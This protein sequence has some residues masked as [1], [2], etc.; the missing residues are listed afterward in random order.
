MPLLSQEERVLQSEG[1]INPPD[2]D[3]AQVFVEDTGVETGAEKTP[4]LGPTIRRPRPGE[5]FIPPMGTQSVPTRSTDAPS[6]VVRRAKKSDKIIYKNPEQQAKQEVGVTTRELMNMP[7]EEKA[8]MNAIRRLEREAQEEEKAERIRNQISTSLP[9]GTQYDDQERFASWN[10]LAML[11]EMDIA[12]SGDL[13][14]KQLKFRESFPEGSLIK[15]ETTDGGVYLARP[16]KNT[17]YRKLGLAPEIAGAIFSEPSVLAGLG[18]VVG[19]V[20]SLGIAPGITTPVLAGAGAAAGSFLQG[21]IE[22]AR[23]YEDSTH[24]TQQA[25]TEGGVA[26]VSEVAFRGMGRILGGRMRTTSEAKALRRAMQTVEELGLEPLVFGQT[27]GPMARGTFRQMGTISPKIERKLTEQQEGLLNYFRARGNDVPAGTSDEVLQEVINAKT[28][29]FSKLIEPGSLT[30]AGAGNTLQAGIEEY[31]KFSRV[32]RDRLYDAA[33]ETT[34]DITFNLHPAQIV[35]AD[36]KVGVL[37]KGKDKIETVTS[38]ILGPDGLPVTR[39]ITTPS[40]PVNVAGNPTGVL[41]SVIND[42]LALDP[43]MSKFGLE[44]RTWTA[45]QQIKTLR[46]RLG[47]LTVSDD[48]SVRKHATTLW[49]T[50]RQV[51]D[52][53][54]SGDPN[55]V[56]SY[57]AASDFNYIREN[58]LKASYTVKALITDTPNALGTTYFKPGHY[59]ELSTIKSI[60][61]NDRWK[62]FTKGFQVDIMNS[63]SA[64]D[65]LNRLRTFRSVDP[66]GL[67]L[68]VDK[69]TLEGLERD[70]RK[71]ARFEANPIYTVMQR[72]LTDGEAYVQLARNSSAGELRELVKVSGGYSSPYAQAARAGIYKDILQ[73]ATEINAQGIEVLNLNKLSKAIG[74]WIQ[75]EKIFSVM[76]QDDIRKLADVSS[77]A[78]IMSVTSD[79]GGGLM[80]GELR[81]RAVEIPFAILTGQLGKATILAQKLVNIDTAAWLLTRTAKI[82]RVQGEEFQWKP[83]GTALMVALEE[84]ERTKE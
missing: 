43:K 27:G 6:T 29:E 71:R 82:G 2:F 58:N 28:T 32:M 13:H 34:D 59:V 77:Y 18:S 67:S 15:V 62:D 42:L 5:T 1:T 75:T 30:R 36:I 16:D 80:A 46:S 45:F 54:V 47:D 21:G 51:M 33:I 56:K 23:G 39:T 60:I 10:M 57:Q 19:S 79:I 44:G 78:S 83:I 25:L 81:S 38:N 84:Y 12:R 9:P 63:P 40:D 35:A 52:N 66:D 48:P 73:S 41:A 31:K 74:D 7:P 50:M 53:P 49:H 61:P 8:E 70:L 3:L 17:P 72:T 65:G 20:A 14:N 37:G 4:P 26:F 68:L 55:F 69:P 64:Q 76:N 24:T 22:S 11:R